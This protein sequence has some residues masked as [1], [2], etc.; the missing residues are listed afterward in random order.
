MGCSTS[1]LPPRRTSTSPRKHLL[2]MESLTIWWKTMKTAWSK[3]LKEWRLFEGCDVILYKEQQWISF[4]KQS[5]CFYIKKSVEP[6]EE[7]GLFCMGNGRE[8]EGRY[9]C[10]LSIELPWRFL[11]LLDLVM[12]SL[13]LGPLFLRS[14]CKLK[15]ILSHPTPCGIWNCLP[16]KDWTSLVCSSVLFYSFFVIAFSWTII[17]TLQYLI[18]Q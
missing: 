16:F 2:Q 11:S 6:S 17:R 3:K 14:I 18:L 4:L 1:N 12:E 15:C 8:G 5:E 13:V 9:I 7:F 10:C